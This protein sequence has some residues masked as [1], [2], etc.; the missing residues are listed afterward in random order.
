MK[1]SITILALLAV[2]ESAHAELKINEVAYNFPT[3]G[4]YQY[5]ELINSG[6]TNDYLD[7]K[8][9]TD[10]GGSGVEGVY[11]FPG[12]VGGTNYPVLPGALVTIAV[13]A[14]LN[15]SNAN[16]ECYAGGTD[17]DNPGVP[18]LT[19]VSG[20]NDLGLSLSG[21]GVMIATGT[22]TS[23]PID[24][25]TVIDGMNYLG[26]DGELVP[27][28]STATDHNPDNSTPSAT[29]LGRCYG[30][31]DYASAVDFFAQPLTFGAT[32]ICIIPV[33]SINDVIVS[34]T[35]T[36]AVFTITLSATNFVPVSFV[37]STSNGT[38]TATNDYTNVNAVA[39]T[40]DVGVRTQ[41]V[42][43][44][45]R[46]DV[47]FEP[48]ETFFVLLSNGVNGVVG[49]G[50]GMAT[51]LNDDPAPPIAF[52]SAFTRIEGILGAVTT[53]WTSVSGSYFQV[54]ST[55]NLVNPD[56]LD[57]SGV[58][59]AQGPTQMTVDTNATYAP[60]FYRIL[61]SY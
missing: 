7:G 10:E 8:I 14:K 1:Y 11:Q 24:T 45:L 58:I 15:T 6:A 2:V 20:V 44:R 28:S 35:A 34:E 22:S 42:N 13:D 21:D 39:V 57:V 36:A 31:G 54:Q 18:N 29:S 4:G 48:D 26:G 50:V 51:I 33:A 49:D 16:W 52:T 59:T 56:W 41:M 38:A 60:R 19:L 40:F 5:V 25:A 17:D 23:A 12:T 3:L 55:T 43:I 46:S 9:I 30:D 53:V 32:N 27:L 37:Y 61:N 47:I